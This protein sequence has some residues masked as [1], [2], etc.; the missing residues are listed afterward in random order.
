MANAFLNAK[1]QLVAAGEL[2]RLTWAEYKAMADE[3]ISHLGKTRL[4]SDLDPEDFAGLRNKLARKWGPQRLKKAIQYIRSIFKHAYDAGLIDRPTR[5]GPGFKRSSMKT[6]RL[7]RAKQG[8]KLFSAQ[9]IHQLLSAASTPM[10]AMILLGIN[11]G[12]GNADCSNLPLA[13]L[14]LETGWVSF[15]RPKTGVARRCSLWPET[16][17]ALKEALAKR[18]APKK[19][20][21][22][23]LVFITKYGLPWGKDIAD[24]P[25]TKE[26]RKLLNSLGINGR[27]NFYTLRHTFRTVADKA[28]D[29]PA[30]DHC[31][32]HETPH[33]SNAYREHLSDRRLKAVADYVRAWLFGA[34][35]Q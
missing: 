4:V 21:H 13:A 34:S 19:E 16:A 18:P 8:P 5:F 12:F 11:C 27:R 29:Q 33:M 7:H 14:D 1:Q 20:E 28:R 22:N 2:S 6:L 15:A 26:M 23:G 3:L 32:G 35:V 25:I 30:V 9:E 24:S 10:R 31:M 17:E